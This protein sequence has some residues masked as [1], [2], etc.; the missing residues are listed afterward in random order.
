M[1]TRFDGKLNVRKVHRIDCLC[2]M[3]LAKHASSHFV[4]VENEFIIRLYEANRVHFRKL[5]SKQK[6][7]RPRDGAQPT[8]DPF[9]EDTDA[10]PNYFRN[11]TT[12]LSLARFLELQQS[13]KF[14]KEKN[15]ICF[16]CFLRG[17][18]V[19][20]KQSQA[21]TSGKLR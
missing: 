3:C 14:L 7:T 9:D 18:T 12:S 8:T 4:E 11:I 5:T 15:L 13:A 16:D 1:V 10:V 21:A 6:N 19:A 17:A 20:Q 2:F